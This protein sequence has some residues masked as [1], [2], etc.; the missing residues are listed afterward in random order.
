MK[1][2]KKNKIDWMHKLIKLLKIIYFF[3]TFDLNNLDNDIFNN[4]NTG[5]KIVIGILAFLCTGIFIWTVTHDEDFEKKLKELDDN[6]KW[7]KPR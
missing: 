7:K 6:D 2:I 3:L 4:L 5:E 1:I